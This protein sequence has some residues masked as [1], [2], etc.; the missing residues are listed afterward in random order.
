V[1]KLIILS[2]VIFMIV[3]P[4]MMASTKSPKKALKRIQILLCVFAILWAIACRVW[5]PSLVPID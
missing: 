1:A 5:Y 3:V 2:I 4:M